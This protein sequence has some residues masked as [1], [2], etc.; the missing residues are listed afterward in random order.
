[1]LGSSD[2]LHL[3]AAIGAVAVIIGSS[4]RLAAPG[5]LSDGALASWPVSS[6]SI[7][8]LARGFFQRS[9]G[10]LLVYPLVLCIVAACLACAILL[11]VR[12]SSPFNSVAAGVIAVTYIL[13]A[14]RSRFGSDGADQMTIIVFLSLALA[15]GIG[16]GRAY[17]V[18]LWFLAAQACLAY[19][20]AGVAKLVSPWW[21]SGA[22]LPGILSTRAYGHP[23]AGRMLARHRSV[24]TAMSWSVILLEC[25]FPLSLLGVQPLTY[26]LLIS[27]VLFHIGAAVL[28]HLDTFLWAFIATYPAIIFCA[29]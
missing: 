26:L 1:M 6:T 8:L 19:F 20:T 4:E 7:P 9:I 16:Q 5:L 18:V 12:P 29:S 13:L 22:A 24:A 27:G 28:M 15:F 23:W 21:R 2:A 25:A 11:T 10:Q 3:S 17:V 14:V